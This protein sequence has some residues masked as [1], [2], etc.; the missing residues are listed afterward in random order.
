MSRPLDARVCSWI[1]V[2]SIISLGFA[3][4]LQYGFGVEPCVLC[5]YQRIPYAIAIGFG[6]LGMLLPL[7]PSKRRT[8]VLICTVLFAAGAGLALYHLGVEQA[9]WAGTAGC[10]G[11]EAAK[12]MT[13]DDLATALSTKPVARCDAV[14]WELFGVSLTTLNLIWSSLLTLLGIALLMERRIWRERRFAGRF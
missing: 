3:F 8:V 11:D 10:T 13:L 14:P 12:T 4:V 9:W 1:A 2:V 7:G 5:T 6:L